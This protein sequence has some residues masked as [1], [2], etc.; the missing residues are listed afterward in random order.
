MA[1]KRGKRFNS[2]D[3]LSKNELREECTRAI[4]EMQKERAKERNETLR[5]EIR[6]AVALLQDM[7]VPEQE[8]RTRICK[9]HQISEEQVREFFD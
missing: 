9:Q 5:Q 7:K 8:I 2:V 6:N 3:E 4:D 1:L